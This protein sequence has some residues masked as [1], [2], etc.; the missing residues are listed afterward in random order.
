[1]GAGIIHPS[2]LLSVKGPLGLL[3]ATDCP[4]QTSGRPCAKQRPLFLS[5]SLSLVAVAVSSVTVV[6][7]PFFP[8]SGF[9]GVHKVNRDQRDGGCFE[10][11]GWKVGLGH[12]SGFTW[13][14]GKDGFVGTVQSIERSGGRGRDP[15]SIERNTA[16]AQNVESQPTSRYS[17][18]IT[19]CFSQAGCFWFS[20]H[21]C[22]FDSC[23]PRPPHY[24]GQVPSLSTCG[25]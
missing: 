20:G 16:S 5:S 21:V 25:A 4:S 22:V 9:L 15:V 12:C 18:I 13:P 6:L 1:M 23:S 17:G 19:Y 2:S 8:E 24:R 11:E 14:S 3:T 10:G 7:F